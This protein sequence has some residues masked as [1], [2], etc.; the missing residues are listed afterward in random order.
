MDAGGL[1]ILSS[2][3]CLRLLKQGGVG[4]IALPGAGAPEIRPGNFVVNERAIIVR[5]GEGALLAAARRG[6]DA[7]FEIDGIDRL[8]HTGWSVLAT[9]SLRELP[10]DDH[11]S[12]LP[13]RA[14]AS[15]TKDRFIA[16]SIKELSGRR[17]P[18]GRGRR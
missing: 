3:E 8:E 1:E 12:A 11:T 17:V 5:T 13:L 9:G 10:G 6:V 4:R 18:A 15:G 2:E 14:W 16:L 7:A